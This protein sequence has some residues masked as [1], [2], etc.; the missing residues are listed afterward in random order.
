MLTKQEG[1]KGF[2]VHWSALATLGVAA[3]LVGLCL[4]PGGLSV[5]QAT[6][7]AGSQA[8][9]SSAATIA[10]FAGPGHVDTGVVNWHGNDW[11]A[12]AVEPDETAANDEPLSTTVDVQVFRWVDNAWAVQGVMSLP[13]LGGP[14]PLAFHIVAVALSGS[15]GPNFEVTATQYD[16]T[17]A[18]VEVRLRCK[19]GASDHPA[20]LVGS[21]GDVTARQLVRHLPGGFGPGALSA[22]LGTWP[23]PPA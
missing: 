23:G 16:I 12:T 13:G 14:N 21:R 5:A 22:P 4:G 3:C 8:E 17:F 6:S 9:R 2:C 10:A 20:E 1:T 19:T 18:V 7:G 11:L 15:A